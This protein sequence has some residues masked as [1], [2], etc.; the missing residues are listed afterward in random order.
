M[1]L[2]PDTE[3]GLG[4]I[5]LNS[6]ADTH[7]SFTNALGMVSYEQANGPDRTPPRPP[8]SPMPK[9]RR[10]SPIRKRSQEPRIQ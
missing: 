5:I 4:L 1:V 7:F 6:N 2:P 3:D 9:H 10:T 8:P